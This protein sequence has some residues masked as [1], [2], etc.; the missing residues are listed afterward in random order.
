MVQKVSPI[1]KGYRTATP[2]LVVNG[3]EQAVDFYATAFAA[4]TLTLTNDPT[5]SYVLHATIKIGNSI[6]VLQ[7]E[8]VE[9]GVLSPVTLGNSGGQTHLY[10]E[11]IDTLW[12]NALE[13]G[14]I[15][16]IEPVNAYWGDRTA[17]LI[18]P[19]GH[20]WSLASRVERVSAEDIKARSA[21][22]FNPQP[23]IVELEA[24]EQLAA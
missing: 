4:S 20:R 17:T 9:M 12:L 5:D 23:E 21:A 15:S 1:P 14:A 22:L 24:V 11:D 2:C 6:I 10:V 18:D 7:Q 16:I 3:I 13:A 19:F 8:S